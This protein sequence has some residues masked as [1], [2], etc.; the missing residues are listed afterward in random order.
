MWEVL[1]A[2]T[3]GMGLNAA[4]RVF[5][6]GTQTIVA[7]E[8]RCEPLHQVL[9]ISARVQQCLDVV[10]EGDEAYPNVGKH[11]PPA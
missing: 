4:A 11:V 10:I 7:W 6:T 9:L 2:R 3:E 1:K 8:R 5:H